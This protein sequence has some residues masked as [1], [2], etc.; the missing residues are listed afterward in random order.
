MLSSVFW[1]RTRKLRGFGCE[2]VRER[3]L[4]IQGLPERGIQL[5]WPSRCRNF[6]EVEMENVKLRILNLPF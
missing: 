3:R 6:L 1:R 4:S 2:R 5:Y